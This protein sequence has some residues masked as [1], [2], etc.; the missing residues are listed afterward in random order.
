MQEEIARLIRDQIKVEHL[1]IEMAGN[2]CTLTIVSDEFDGLSPVKETTA[3]L[4]VFKR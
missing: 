3:R 4:S 2:H 1:D